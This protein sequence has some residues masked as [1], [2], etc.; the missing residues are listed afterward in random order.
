MEVIEVG[1]LYTKREAAGVLNC[2][3]ITVHRLIKSKKLGCFRVASKV[4]I[5]REH[6]G[7]FL[8]RHERKPK[9]A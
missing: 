5:S 3:E 7:D 2:S 8:Q 9:A 1:R 4:L 6:I